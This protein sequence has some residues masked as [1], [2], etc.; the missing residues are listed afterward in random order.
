MGLLLA[1]GPKKSIE[2]TKPV[3]D[4][5]K[6]I[7]TENYTPVVSTVPVFSAD[8]AYAMIE[9][10][11]SF[12][13]RVPNSKGHKACGDFLIARLKQFTSDV[14]VQNATVRAYTG[15][16]LQIRNIMARFDKDN[17]NRIAFF[18][19]WDTRPFADRDKE[20]P[21]QPVMGADDGGSGVAV[22][23][24]IARMLQLNPPPVG[25]DIVLF[26][27][28]DYGDAGGDPETYCLGSQ[29]WSRNLPVPG[30]YAKYGILLDM[31]GAAN[32]RFCKEGWSVK[33]ASSV[34]EKV[35]NMGQAL[36][37][38]NYFIMKQIEPITDDHYFV[39]TIARIPTINII[40][41]DPA[42]NEV[43]FGDHWHTRKDDLSIIDKKT[44]HAVG[45]TLMNVIY[46]ENI[47]LY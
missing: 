46:S 42:V 22:L 39:N 5:A 25:V 47:N 44:L 21:K 18:A 23:L 43:G 14:I 20:N 28:E 12:G 34:V 6:H 24:E 10:Q 45:T 19:H 2:P 35:W 40:N 33:Y 11:L 41:F 26:D 31:V 13:H 9:K 30:Y 16:S 7:G 29:Y 27:G 3:N 37:L 8:S 38:G 15:E 36:G 4:T 17:T 1:C 32:A